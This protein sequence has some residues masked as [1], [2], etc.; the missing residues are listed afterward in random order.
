MLAAAA[1]GSA[2]PAKVQVGFYLLN[3]YDI[4]VDQGSFTIEGW[5]W[6][7]AEKG[8]ELDPPKFREFLNCK[9]YEVLASD[10]EEKGGKSWSA[11]KIRATLIADFDLRRFP[12]D[13][14]ELVLTV[15]EALEEVDGVVYEADEKNSNLDSSFAEMEG[16]R[17]VAM[18]VSS[19]AHSYRSTFGDPTKDGGSTY[20]RFTM[21]LTIERR[22]EGV[23]IRTLIG[24]VTAILVAFAAFFMRTDSDDIFASRLS[25]IVGMV[26]AT[27]LSKDA[28]Q[29]IVGSAMTPTVVD[30]LHNFG[31][32]HL[33]AMIALTL[34]SRRIAERSEDQTAA[35]RFD[36]YSLLG[37]AASFI[38]ISIYLLVQ[39]RS[40]GS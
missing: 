35:I 10:T 39:V 11:E 15:E 36:R 22:G 1:E 37:I 30:K 20:S 28:A 12:H 6:Y 29:G 25:L 16:W 38:A 21:R 2:P 31:L 5:L 4:N 8:R 17:I 3:V 26:F 33:F 27:L 23:L 14:H 13:R 40:G 9:K 19:G 18:K 24:L 32:L 34:R 7:V